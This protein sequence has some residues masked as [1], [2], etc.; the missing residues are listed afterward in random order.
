MSG[1]N[2][3]RKT[4]IINRQLQFRMIAT[5]LLSVLG[6]LLLFTGIML[7]YYWITTLA[8]EN[9]FDEYIK[10]YERVESKDE[11]GA[12]TSKSVERIT[13]RWSIVI[14]PLLIN[15]LIIMVVIAIIGIFYSHKIAG[16]VFRIK[17]DIDKVLS[18]DKDV[19]IVLRKNDK[20]HDLAD[21]VNLLIE[22]L[23]KSK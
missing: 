3:K 11:N 21:S 16:P 13:N 7:G 5:F 18:G 6:A 1:K 9:V 4:Y 14:P 12:I 19:R 2:Y 10:I 22:E 20:L 17:A 8:G 15:N 23:R